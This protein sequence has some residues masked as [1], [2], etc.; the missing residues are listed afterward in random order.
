VSYEDKEVLALKEYSLQSGLNVIKANLNTK[1]C[2]NVYNIITTSN[3]A[4]IT[5]FYSFRDTIE[6]NVIAS[7]PVTVDIYA[8]GTVINETYSTYVDSGYTS[9][10]ILDIKNDIMAGA[11]NIEAYTDKY[12][13]L[14]R[15]SNGQL[16]AD[17][18]FNPSLIL[19]NIVTANAPSLYISNTKYKIIG[20]D[21]TFGTSYRSKLSLIRT[22]EAE[23]EEETEEE[24]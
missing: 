11:S 15:L 8:Y 17:G 6:I 16:N 19:G 14:I 4:I 18:W 13:E 20:I 22:V 24:N 9:G 5:T 1:K 3:N 23:V 2:V 7:S 10:D 12:G 21:I